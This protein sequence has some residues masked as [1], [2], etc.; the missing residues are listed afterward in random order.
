MLFKFV[1]C[2]LGVVT[3]H[4]FQFNDFIAMTQLNQVYKLSPKYVVTAQEETL[5]FQLNEKSILDN[6]KDLCKNIE[7]LEEQHEQI[8]NYIN[9]ISI[10]ARKDLVAQYCSL[11][12]LIYSGYLH[13][14]FI[15]IL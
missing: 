1:L 7:S 11:N 13:Y 4:K 15:Y 2:V 6:I 9:V 14:V 8:N 12:V 10:V 5:K 3:L